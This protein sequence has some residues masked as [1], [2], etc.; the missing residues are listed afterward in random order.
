MAL[1]LILAAMAGARADDVYK[2]VDAQGVTH[3]GASPPAGS[4]ARR[5]DLPA[6]PAPS[7]AAPAG[8]RPAPAPA[9]APTPTPPLPRASAPRVGD[10]LRVQDCAYARLQVEAL[11]RGGPVYRLDAQGQRVFLPDDRRDAEI[12][13]WRERVNEQCAGVQSDDA[14]RQL[15]AR[16]AADARCATEQQRLQELQAPGGRVPDADI[17]AQR[18][19]VQAVCGTR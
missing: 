16:A 15:R 3:Y 12:R 19:R 11:E 7:S 8:A 4:G 13:L 14:T 9:P 18:A 2:W 1:A 6:P 10:A 5:L 17:A